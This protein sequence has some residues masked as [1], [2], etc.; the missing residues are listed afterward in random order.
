MKKKK[1]IYSYAAEAN[2]YHDVCRCLR[3]PTA[4]RMTSARHQP[5]PRLRSLR[6]PSR[7]NHLRALR[8]QLQGCMNMIC[9]HKG[10]PKKDSLEGGCR[11]NVLHSRPGGYCR[12]L[13]G[14][15][16][17][18]I[19]RELFMGLSGTCD[20]HYSLIRPL[21]SLSDVMLRDSVF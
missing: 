11:E 6:F 13:E 21:L 12:C 19:D 4:T 5:P 10:P 7:R 20:L 16:T 1:K 9:G 18:Y 8:V 14:V 15:P 2:V 3:F 17:V